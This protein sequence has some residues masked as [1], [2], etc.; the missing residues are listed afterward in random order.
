MSEQLEE[1]LER[2]ARIFNTQKYNMYDGPGIR[3]I[4]FFKGCP[5]RCKWCSNPESQRRGF[6]VMFKQTACV[7]CGACVEACP[8]GVHQFVNGE[9]VVD[10]TKQ[11]LGCGA[12]EKACLQKALSI[13]G[14]D[15]KICDLVSFMDQDADFYRMSGGGVTLGGG[16]VLAQ[17]EAARALLAACKDRGYHTAI[18]TCGYTKTETILDIARYV[19]LFL[20]DIKQMDP[21]KHKQWTGV[22]NE[23]ILANIRALLE[24]GFN[25]RVRMP[26]LH[27]VNDDKAEIDA[28]IEFFTPYRYQKNFDGVDLL[29]YHKLGVGTY[30]QLGRDY[31][32]E[33]DPSLSEDDLNR[34]EGW[35]SEADFKVN[36]VRH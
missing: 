29:P 18:E 2:R 32:I 1:S 19:D 20:F 36:L 30:A 21:V 35:I 14:E 4:A 12:C 23:Q 15:R 28:M 9:H 26:L 8:A 11:C 7:N 34:I 17:P 6:E 25:V 24:N 5:L 10:R 16:E 33:G 22:N 27:G 31:E 13:M 3:S